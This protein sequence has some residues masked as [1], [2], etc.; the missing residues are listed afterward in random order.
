MSPDF[1]DDSEEQEEQE[2]G[3]SEARCHRVIDD[4]L[5]AKPLFDEPKVTLKKREVPVIKT[6]IEVEAAEAKKRAVPPFRH[7]CCSSTQTTI[8]MSNT[9]VNLLSGPGDAVSAAEVK[10]IIE[11]SEQR[12]KKLLLDLHTRAVQD[13]NKFIEEFDDLKKGMKAVSTKKQNRNKKRRRYRS[14]SS[15]SSD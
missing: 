11:D 4:S 8:T 1:G 9:P 14:S 6:K 12:T 2:V 7:T 5:N 10:K 15:S 13:C 3:A